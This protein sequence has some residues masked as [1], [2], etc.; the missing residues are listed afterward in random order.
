MERVHLGVK[1]GAQ[2]GSEPERE[3]GM[4]SAP[5]RHQDA[6]DLRDAPLLDDCDVT[7]CVAH[8]LVDGGAEHWLVRVL[9]LAGRPTTPA[10][11]DEVCLVLGSQLHDAFRGTSPDTHHGPQV[12]AVRRELQHPLQQPACLPRAS[13]ALGQ[14]HAFRHLDDGHRGQHTAVLQ[15]RR[16][17][18]H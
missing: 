15:K 13:R 2:R 18:T 10:E 3:L 6:L 16:A 4:G 14:R 7:R 12:D 1:A 5:N 8:D 11:D 17:D 9:A